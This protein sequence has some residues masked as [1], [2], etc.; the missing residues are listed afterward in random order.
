LVL[1]ADRPQVVAF[2]VTAMRGISGRVAGA[3]EVAIDPL[4]RREATD[5][6][7]N[8]AFRSLPAG[9]FTLTAKVDGLVV[10]HD[11]TL[12]AEPAKL[13]DIVFGPETRIVE[14]LAPKSI[15]PGAFA[16][17]VGAFRD[18]ANARQLEAR[19]AILGETSFTDQKFGL[20]FVRTG[21]FTSRSVAT[22]SVERLRGAG[23][24]SYVVSSR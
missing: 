16:V 20:L 4:G 12:P 1:E 11:L 14:T 18:P 7:G 3:R 2:L 10:T 13:R 21:P 23:I 15:V 9:H 17:Q 6:S 22:A 19:L 24:A 5:A 8:F